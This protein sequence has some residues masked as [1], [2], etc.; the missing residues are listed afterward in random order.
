[1]LIKFKY[2][3]FIIILVFLN[4][5][6]A[7][8]DCNA[9]LI[10]QVITDQ[11][12]DSFFLDVYNLVSEFNY[13]EIKKSGASAVGG[14][15]SYIDVFKADLDASTSYEDFNKKRQERF[16]EFNYKEKSDR[17]KSYIRSY[18]DEGQIDAWTKCVIANSDASYVIATV[19]EPPA[20]DFKSFSIKV[21]YKM[22]EGLD[23]DE[24]IIKSTGGKLPPNVG[25]KI[26]K[27]GGEK[28]MI[29]HFTGA[30][31]GALITFEMKSGFGS[32]SI[33]VQRKP[34]KLSPSTPIIPA[35]TPPLGSQEFRTIV[36]SGAEAQCPI[37]LIENQIVSQEIVIPLSNDSYVKSV[38]PNVSLGSVSVGIVKP[39]SISMSLLQNSHNILVGGYPPS[40][41]DVSASHTVKL[42]GSTKSPGK[43][44]QEIVIHYISDKI[45]I[46][47]PLPPEPPLTLTLFLN[48][49]CGSAD[50]KATYY[51][52]T[53]DLGGFNDR[54]S[55]LL[56][57][58]IDSP[59]FI[60]KLYQHGGGGYGG[61]T[62]EYGAG[63]CQNIQ[64][65]LLGRVS[66]FRLIKVTP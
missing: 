3:F 48:A 12:S 38:H 62:K 39:M 30:S 14:S 63:T 44:S 52:N 17:S 60:V 24:L 1:M 43:W 32:D 16:I 20:N 37:K 28:Q 22:A 15:G 31:K 53:L 49:G 8:S 35:T 34:K 40:E 64:A 50:T 41:Q 51:A 36:C 29:V 6:Y 2:I 66:A 59:K 47:P 25:G 9:V 18:L 54:A 42:H 11:S 58:G 13:T 27:P 7:L 5:S 65:P 56:L 26:Y 57:A 61:K 19:T 46:P 10:K 55:S 23:T 45:P 21:N 4:R 33:Y